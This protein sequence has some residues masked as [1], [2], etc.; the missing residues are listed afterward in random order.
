MLLFLLTA[1]GISLAQDTIP[2]SPNDTPPPPPGTPIDENIL[3][4]FLVGFIVGLYK[5]RKY[6]LNN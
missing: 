6:R 4:L 5:I 3:F 1:R 2:P